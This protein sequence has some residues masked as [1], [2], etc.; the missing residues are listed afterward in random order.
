MF[1]HLSNTLEGLFHIRLYDAQE[2]FDHYNRNLI[3]ND[4]KALYSLLLSKYY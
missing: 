1:A 2:K 4:H 3:D